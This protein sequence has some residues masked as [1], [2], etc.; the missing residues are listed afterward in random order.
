MNGSQGYPKDCPVY[1]AAIIGRMAGRC[2]ALL[3]SLI[4]IP[5]FAQDEVFIEILGIAQDAGYPQVACYKPHC[6]RAWENPELHRDASSIAVIDQR[7]KT[8]YLFDATPDMREQLY[9][10]HM[11]APDAAFRLD[12]VFLTHAHMGHYTGLIH[13]GREATGARDVPVYAMPRMK[14]Y[15]ESNGPWDQLVSLG[16]ILL[17]PLADNDPVR[18]G[19][20]LV[21]TPFLVPHRDEYSETVGYRIDGPNKSAV[22]IPDIDKWNMWEVDIRDVVKSVDYALL[23]ATFFRDGELG[24]RDMSTIR[25]PFVAESMDLFESLAPDEKARVIFIHMNHTNPLLIDGSEEQQQVERR[26]YRFARE[27]MRLDL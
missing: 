22:F 14:A 21:V 13:F 7:P 24:G 15:L 4:L 6:L 3:A 25:H 16:N 20:D 5:A 18:L 17:R 11:T 2:T 27:G 9:A 10:L 26:G 19:D 23:D 8:K 1:C 12:G